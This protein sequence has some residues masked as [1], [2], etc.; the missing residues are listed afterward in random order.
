MVSGSSTEQTKARKEAE[1]L[2]MIIIEL[3]DYER[4]ILYPTA[5][6]RI[7]I[8]LDDGVLVNYNRFG[9]A[10]KEV[11]GLNDKKTR[12]KVEGFEWPSFNC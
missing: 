5:T 2:K 6:D 3:Q 10:I 4:D 8:D 9:K 7:D 12:K 1:K 11:A